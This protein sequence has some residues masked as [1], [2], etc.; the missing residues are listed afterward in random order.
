MKSK[1]FAIVF[2]LMF[3]S[4]L[5]VEC[6]LGYG[7]GGG[8]GCGGG[9]STTPLSDYEKQALNIAM[10]EEYKAK[11][12]YR[13][14]VDTFGPINPFPWIIRDEQ[15][16]VNWVA[17]LLTKYGFP[18]PADSWTGNVPLEFLSKQQACE[19]GAQAEFDNAA[20]YDQMIPQISHTDIISVFGRLRDVSQ[21]KHL[22]AFQE[23]AAIYA[24]G[25]E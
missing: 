13:K 3:V 17:N 4:I 18:V 11:A 10:D 25:G 20:V 23:W 9:A 6:N 12:I 19:I 1:F 21:Y 16:H 22:P 5:T 7:A 24:A 2:L 15:M 8:C 14:V